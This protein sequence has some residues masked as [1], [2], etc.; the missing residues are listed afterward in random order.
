MI[1]VRPE[2]VADVVFGID[3]GAADELAAL[4]LLHSDL[5]L[6]PCSFAVAR[7]SAMRAAAVN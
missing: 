7:A 6:V 2:Y 4:R 1:V 3:A 5:R